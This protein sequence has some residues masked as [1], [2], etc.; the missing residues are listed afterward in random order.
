MVYTEEHSQEDLQDF[1]GV[2]GQHE[3][4][5]RESSALKT[6]IQADLKDGRTQKDGKKEKMH[7]G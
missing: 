6:G 1:R 4:Q 5:R 7:F 2:G 3:G